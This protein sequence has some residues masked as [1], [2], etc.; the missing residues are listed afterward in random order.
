MSDHL[1]LEERLGDESH[2]FCRA[3]VR[4]ASGMRERRRAEP[5]EEAKGS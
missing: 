5:V 1:A 4:V 3:E 2:F